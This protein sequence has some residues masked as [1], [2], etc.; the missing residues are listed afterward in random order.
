MNREQIDRRPATFLVCTNG[1]RNGTPA[2]YD[3]FGYSN[4]YRQGKAPA[5][6]A[7]ADAALAA[8]LPARIVIGKPIG[9]ALGADVCGSAQAMHPDMLA[10]WR[11]LP[12]WI[13]A[14][15]AD[16]PDLTVEIYTGSAYA[17]TGNPQT[18]WTPKAGARPC[19][20]TDTDKQQ[21]DFRTCHGFWI[22]LGAAGLWLDKGSAADRFEATTR[23]AERATSADAFTGRPFRI[24]S[25]AASNCDELRIP[26]MAR[27]EFYYKTG[28]EDRTA[29]PATTEIHWLLQNEDQVPDHGAALWQFVNGIAD[30]GLIPMCAWPFAAAEIAEIAATHPN[31]RNP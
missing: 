21:A 29:D 14:R 4:R 5:I 12:E 13:D 19:Y 11:I 20:A 28:T 6:L 16:H 22:D 24:G 9:T 26:L 1:E 18:L 25:E 2:K 23:T 15:R 8:G 30:R 10:S 7:Q 31:L 17:P 27:T 3:P